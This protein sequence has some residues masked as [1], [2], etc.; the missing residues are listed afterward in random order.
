MPT[1]TETSARERAL[2]KNSVFKLLDYTIY[3]LYHYV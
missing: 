2:L 3:L 1:R